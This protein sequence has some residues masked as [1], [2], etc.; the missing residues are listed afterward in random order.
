MTASSLTNA[1]ALVL[2][3]AEVACA[4]CATRAR[5]PVLCKHFARTT[6]YRQRQGVE[7]WLRGCGDGEAL[8]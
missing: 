6:N 8:G 4:G 5:P 7:S 2:A 1:L 3:V